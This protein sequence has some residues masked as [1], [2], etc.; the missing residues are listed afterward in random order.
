MNNYTGYNKD[1]KKP[2]KKWSERSKVNPSPFTVNR[3]PQVTP[4]PFTVNREPQV[5]PSPTV[6]R[7]SKVNPS[8]ITVNPEP[9]ERR[10]SKANPSSKITLNPEPLT[11]NRK[12]GKLAPLMTEEAKQAASIHELSYDFGCRITRLFQYLTEDAQYKEYIQSKQIHRS[13][14]SI[15]ANV[16]ESKHAQS[17]ADFLS[18]MSIAYKEADETDFWLNSLH[19]NGYLDDKQYNSLRRDIDRILKVLASIVK[20]M[21]QKIEENKNK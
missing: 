16:R 17:E 20:T 14:T 6:R 4:S 15:G 13:G 5:T 2:Y 18:K 11:V 7:Q 21:K 1:G 19:D 10:R 3:E 8:P 9:K 12:R